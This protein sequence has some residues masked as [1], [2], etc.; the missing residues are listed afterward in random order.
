[1]ALTESGQRCYE[2]ALE[3]L[4]QYQRL[5]DD[6]TQIKTRPEGMIRIGCSFGLGAAI[7]RQPL[8]NLCAIILSYRC[9]LNCSIGK[10]I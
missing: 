2:H 1:M 5:V 7:L 9:I 10:L 6:V 3:I 8:P 4:T